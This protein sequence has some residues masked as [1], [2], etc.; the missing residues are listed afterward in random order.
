MADGRGCHRPGEYKRP[1]Y[2][3]YY[4]GFNTNT[5]MLEM[6]ASVRM[7]RDAG[8]RGMAS[9]L[10]VGGPDFVA[11]DPVTSVVHNLFSLFISA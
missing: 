3:A 1:F 6:F 9:W 2:M 8:H 7:L 10:R 11:Q 4:G 5:T